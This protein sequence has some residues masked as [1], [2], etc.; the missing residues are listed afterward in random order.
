MET[1]STHCYMSTLKFVWPGAAHLPASPKL[2]LV[3]DRFWPVTAKPTSRITVLDRRRFIA[4]AGAGAA[5][6][7]LL[8]W[9]GH[10]AADGPPAPAEAPPDQA[11]PGPGS[12]SES[13]QQALERVLGSATPATEGFSIE[14]P[15]LAENGNVVPYKLVAE[16]PMTDTDYIKRLHLLSTA[17]P[18]AMVASFELIP[19]TGKA[20]VAG[21]MRLARTQDVIGIA[22]KSDGTFLIAKATVEV[23]IGGCGIE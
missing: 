17:N 20:T 6:A 14:L 22:E 12:Y 11:A 18:E 19:A 16:S 1:R 3:Q 9:S 7:A 8:A 2:S 21:R 23:T 10:V 15:E 4:G 5:V 13:Y